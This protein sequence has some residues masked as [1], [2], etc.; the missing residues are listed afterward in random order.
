[1]LLI[2]AFCAAAI[3]GEPYRG[4]CKVIPYCSQQHCR[5]D[6]PRQPYDMDK[7]MADIFDQAEFS[8]ASPLI[9]R[10]AFEGSIIDMARLI[11]YVDVSVFLFALFPP[12]HRSFLFNLLKSPNVTDISTELI[13]FVENTYF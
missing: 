9:V 7:K 6:K 11:I 10:N 5:Q 3:E 4:A 2:C 13:E 8:G 12:K 1:M